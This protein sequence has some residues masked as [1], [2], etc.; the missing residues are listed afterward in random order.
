MIVIVRP[1]GEVEII[2]HEKDASFVSEL[3][4]A[5]SWQRGGH[6]VPAAVW[7][8]ATFRLV[9]KFFSRLPRL[10]AWTRSWKGDWLVDLT[11]SSGPILGPFAHRSAA[12][13]AEEEW[14]ERRS[15]QSNE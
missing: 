15:L 9:R 7:K 5:T 13:A 10:V 6:V 4:E 1:D 11:R 2:A 14:L 12:I 3:G 8:R